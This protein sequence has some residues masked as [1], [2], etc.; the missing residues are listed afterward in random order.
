MGWVVR[1]RKTGVLK[2]LKATPLTAVEY[3]S[4]QMASR[5]F[6]IMFCLVIVW[7][8]CDIIFSFDVKGSY[9][10]LF[11]IFFL[12]GLSLTTLGLLIASRGISEEFTSG[13]VNIISW[14]MM[15]LSEV[16]FS[17]EDAP[18]FV[19]TIS[20]AIPLTNIISS[21]RKIMNYGYQLS[22]LGTELAIIIFSIVF[23]LSLGSAL[24]SWQK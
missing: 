7:T 20:K 9:I 21:A 14:P 18:E 8:G 12:G 13:L 16:W 10:D 2:R 17:I 22:D 19:K 4:A 15:F 23:F 24:F 3:L 11:I 6:V 1:Y 5:I